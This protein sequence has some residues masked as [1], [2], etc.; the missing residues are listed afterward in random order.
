MRLIDAD[1][2]AKEMKCRQ[3]AVETAI[4]NPRTDVYYTDKEHWEGVLCTY[5]EAKLTLD[6]M[7]TVDAAPVVHGKWMVSE[8]G[9]WQYCSICGVSVEVDSM[10][11]CKASEDSNFKY[12]P[13]CGAKMDLE[14]TP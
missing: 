10:F 2:Y 4:E 8:N 12:C 14:E 9:L 13:H 7:P 3:N 5:A 6:N 11:M 1:E